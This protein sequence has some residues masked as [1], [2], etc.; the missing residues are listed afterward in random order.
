MRIFDSLKSFWNLLLIF[1]GIIIAYLLSVVIGGLHCTLSGECS[2]AF[3]SVGFTPYVGVILGYIFFVSILL[4]GCGNY[5][6]YR[7]LLIFIGPIVFLPLYSSSYSVVQEF[8]IVFG[9][10]AL[11]GTILR[12]ALTK[13]AP[14]FMTKIS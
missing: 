11:L 3:A 7:W 1:I 14:S 4:V 12:K 13:F 10:G 9:I 5:N 2:A 6:R 8:V